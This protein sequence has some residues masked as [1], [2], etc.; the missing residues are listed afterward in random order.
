MPNS[1]FYTIVS[2]SYIKQALT[3]IESTRNFHP[4]S[5][6]YIFI[7]DLIHEYSSE[8]KNLFICSLHNLRKNHP[9]INNFYLY[10]NTIETICALK[11]FVAKYLLNIYE[12]VI[13]TDSDTFYFQNL[14]L[15]SNAIA[16]GGFTPHRLYPIKNRNESLNIFDSLAFKYGFFN[17]GFFILTIKNLDFIE[18]WMGKLTFSCLYAPELFL[19][20]DQKWI[21][22]GYHFF[23]LNII[24]D[25][26]INIGPWNL[27]ERCIS[28]SGEK[29]LVNN[30][31]IKMIHFSGVSQSNNASQINKFYSIEQY[32]SMKLNTSINNFNKL[33]MLWLE[34]QKKISREHVKTISIIE[35][36]DRMTFDQISFFAKNKRINNL[37]RGSVI[38]KNSNL[39]KVIVKRV[40]FKLDAFLSKAQSYKFGR[41]YILSDFYNLKS[42]INRFFP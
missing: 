3:S 40:I 42:L 27:D 5:D 2:S 21:D 4:E 39:M 13:Y 16:M 24:T 36:L 33:S 37:S 38:S 17:A 28:N 35:N 10:Y 23:K 29:Y 22:L 15:N 9:E 19:F 32:Q 1:V 18:W 12:T 20:V 7:I 25:E 11:P 34:R 41:A 31:E 8:Q 6:F 30:K 26:T 14:N